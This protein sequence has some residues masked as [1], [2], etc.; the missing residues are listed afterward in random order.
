MTKIEDLPFIGERRKDEPGK[1]PRHFWRV[2][3]SGDYTLD[4]KIGRA[5]ALQYLAYEEANLDGSGILNLIVADMPRPLTGLENGFLQMVC[6]AAS[7]GG[8][9]ARRV[10]AYWKRRFEEMP[11]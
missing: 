6:F 8:H 3:P 4:C 10:D 1:W 7:A 11:A 5:F 2:S 9:E